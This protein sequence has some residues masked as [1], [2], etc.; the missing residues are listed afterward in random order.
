MEV[1][2]KIKKIFD[3]QTFSSGFTKKELILLTQE[4]YPQTLAIEFHQDRTDLLDK[5]NVGDDVKISVNLRGREWTNPEG[6]VKYFNS[7]VGWRIER[8][9]QSSENTPPPADF[10]SEF[11]DLS[12][13]GD[14]EDDLPF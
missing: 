5:F 11:N 14:K 12:A 2:G 7:I 3:L 8:L 13:D 6:V 4:Q 1:T 9:D 10:N